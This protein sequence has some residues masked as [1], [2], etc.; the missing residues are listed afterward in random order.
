MCRSPTHSGTHRAVL[1]A[2]SFGRPGAGGRLAFA[3]PEKGYA[4]AYA[5]NNLVWDGQ[6][7]DPRWIGWLS[8][9]REIAPD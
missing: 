9:L 3:R 1:A 4:V 2:E 5:C 7:R 8:A 6:S